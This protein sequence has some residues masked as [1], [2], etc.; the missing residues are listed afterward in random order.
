MTPGTSVGLFPTTVTIGSSADGV[1]WTQVGRENGY[2]GAAGENAWQGDPT[3]ARYVR[4]RATAT[5]SASDG[6]YYVKV[7][8]VA[9]YGSAGGN[10]I[11]ATWTAPADS[12]SNP[13]SGSACEYDLRYSR[14][15]IT[16]GNFGAATAAGDMPAPGVVGAA[17][18]ATV[19]VGSSAG[20]LFVA[21]KTC[22]EA[23]NWSGISNVTTAYAS[24]TGFLT[25][26]A[27]DVLTAN[28]STAP[29][30]ALSVGQD[31]VQPAV[32]VSDSPDFAG[33]PLRIAI[34]PG[35]TYWKPTPAQWVAIKRLAAAGGTAYWRL[36]GRSAQFARIA[37]SGKAILFP[38]SVID[39][40]AL[41]ASHDVDGDEA[42]WP[43]ASA[44][45]VFRW[46]A[47]ASGMYYFYLDISTDEAMPLKNKKVSLTLGPVAGVAGTCQ[48][49]AAEWVKIRKL[50]ATSGGELYWRVRGTD[51]DK[52]FQ[53]G[54]I[55]RKLVMDGGE[56]TVGDLDL[57]SAAPA[58]SWTS[59]AI[60]H[61][62]ELCAA[63]FST[64][65]G[66][67]ATGGA[68]ITIPG[69][70]VAGTSYAF[71]ARD[72]AAIRKFAAKRGVMELYYRVRGCDAQ[73][74]FIAYSET[75][76]ANVP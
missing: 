1:E 67:P 32:E 2:K 10:C 30:I 74:A 8:Q 58:L 21:V 56:W 71:T 43:D 11:K 26:A 46:N 12:G 61:G 52:V 76:T 41:E 59:T 17:E 4:I 65:A 25:T 54:S 70:G 44:P 49:K 35:S 69:K 40:L 6:L 16:E 23:P 47:P 33:K 60:G 29:V 9:V 55:V 57:G 50:A 42:V 51:R 5:E 62:M 14:T 72:V 39:G 7:G 34:A 24:P 22:D 31:T 38:T 27:E 20:K 13:A 37:T 45:P 19:A 66:F 64:G 63:Q 15:P 28:L 75:K 36:Q 73:K 53:T 3:E 68:V 48:P 18:E